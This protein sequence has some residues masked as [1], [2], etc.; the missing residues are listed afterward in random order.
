MQFQT[1]E[2]CNFMV[3]KNPAS[4]TFPGAVTYKFEK[5]DNL[6]SIFPR[7]EEQHPFFTGGKNMFWEE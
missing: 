4:M 6:D 3:H 5:C 1:C 2:K 7:C